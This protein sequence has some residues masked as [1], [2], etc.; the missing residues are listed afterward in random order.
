MVVELTDQEARI[1]QDALVRK[2]QNLNRAMNEL[3]ECLKKEQHFKFHNMM[4]DRLSRV[5]VDVKIVKR[6]LDKFHY[7]WKE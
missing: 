2:Y 1:V 3:E 5:S 6:L 7:I 4:A